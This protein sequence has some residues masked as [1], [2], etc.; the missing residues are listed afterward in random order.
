MHVYM[1]N[2]LVF[3]SMQVSTLQIIG[4][5]Y[6]DKFLLKFQ[7]GCREANCKNWLKLV[8]SRFFGGIYIQLVLR[9]HSLHDYEYKEYVADVMK[10]NSA[11]FPY[12]L[13]D[14]AMLCQTF[15][16]YVVTLDLFH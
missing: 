3:L 11:C 14:T 5:Y 1:S 15:N 6:I 8:K 12:Q 16:T 13:L 10:I 9:I 2:W 7:P 4:Y